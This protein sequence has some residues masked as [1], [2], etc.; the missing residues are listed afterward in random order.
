MSRD[1]TENVLADI[2]R[3]RKNKFGESTLYMM[4]VFIINAEEKVGAL[5]GRRIL[6]TVCHDRKGGRLPLV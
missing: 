1:L 2:V 5:N 6:E 4:K 3:Y